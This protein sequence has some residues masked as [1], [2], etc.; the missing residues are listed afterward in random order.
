MHETVT[1]Q[2]PFQDAIYRIISHTSS[3]F[4]RFLQFFLVCFSPYLRSELSTIPSM[5]NTPRSFLSLPSHFIPT[6]NTVPLHAPSLPLQ[7]PSRAQP[8][9]HLQLKNPYRVHT[10]TPRSAPHHPPNIHLYPERS[11]SWCRVLAESGTFRDIAFAPRIR[12]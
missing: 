2:T 5:L 4:L 3:G 6:P 12:I 7:P 1:V 10:Q 11:Q 9:S 8:L